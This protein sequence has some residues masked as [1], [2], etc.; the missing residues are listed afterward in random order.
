M[1][2]PNGHSTKVIDARR[3]A[4]A[5]QMYAELVFGSNAKSGTKVYVVR[6]ALYVE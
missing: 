5:L 4:T 3:Q 6:P 2:C 1:R